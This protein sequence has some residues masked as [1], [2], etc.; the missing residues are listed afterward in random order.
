MFAIYTPKVSIWMSKSFNLFFQGAHVC[1]IFWVFF[2]DLVGHLVGLYKNWKA[3]STSESPIVEV[4]LKLAVLRTEN[5]KSK[6][7]E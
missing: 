3:Y 1:Q 2:W 7:I 4:K 5:T 6:K